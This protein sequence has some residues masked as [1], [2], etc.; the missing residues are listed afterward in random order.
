MTTAPLS[1]SYE[2]DTAA[3]ATAGTGQ[4]DQICRAPWAGT[5]T[6]A[7]WIPEAN[8]TGVASNNKTLN[9]RNRGQDGTG[10]TIMASLALGSGTNCVAFDEKALT[11]SG[12]G[13]NLNCAE[14]DII[15]YSTTVGGTGMTL[16]EGKARIT[17]SRS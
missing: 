2:E 3:E 14:G 12:T 10:T 7:S 16:P 4:E 6:A 8:V 17:L 11:L 13:A 15:S 9:I 5:L 1:E